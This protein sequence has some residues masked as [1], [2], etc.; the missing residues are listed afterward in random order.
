[1]T[2][3]EHQRITNIQI[4]H[5]FQIE[6][7]RDIAYSR[8]LRWIGKIARMGYN[9]MPRKMLFCCLNESRPVGRPLTTIRHT[10]LDALRRIKAI[11][12][13]DVCGK[14]QDWFPLAKNEKEWEKVRERLLSRDRELGD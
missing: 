5:T 8:Q 3:V 2:Q 9:R 14:V 10:Y 4:L 6:S 11:Q 7:I 1:M 12:N 13:D